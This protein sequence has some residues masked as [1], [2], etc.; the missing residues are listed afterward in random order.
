MAAMTGATAALPTKAANV[1]MVVNVEWYFLSHRLALANALQAAGLQVAV[2]AGVE[3]GQ[4]SKVEASGLRFH[5]LP[6]LRRSIS[7]LRELGTF[8]YLLRLYRQQQPDLVHHITI[9]PVIYGSLAARLAKVPAVINT[10]PGLGY[11]FLGQ[12]WKGMTIRW[13]VS[14]VYQ[15]ALSR[16]NVRVI[17]QNTNDR[18]LFVSRGLARADRVVVIRGSGVDV[19]RFAPS[20]LPVGKQMVLLPSRLLWDKGI[21][22]LIEAARLLR[23]QGRAFRLVLAGTPDEANP[24]SIPKAVLL[25]WQEAGVVEWWG[26]QEDMPA[27]LRQATIVVLPSYREGVPKALLEAAACSRPIVATDVPG[28]REVVR[29]GENGFLVPPRDAQALAGALGTLL[30]DRDLQ[31]RMGQRGR[32]LAVS[33]FSEDR[34]IRETMAVY[35]EALGPKWPRTGM[36]A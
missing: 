12:G 33:E 26:L 16:P 34:I 17:F 24:Q 4:D 18:D 22:E 23:E 19:A 35:R 8:L 3:R 13:F 32:E 11:T 2:A 36:E 14:R 21:G 28:C 29:N 15:L 25:K 27:V 30:G 31:E 7:P 6:L 1:L 10:V 9:K 20:A 5:A